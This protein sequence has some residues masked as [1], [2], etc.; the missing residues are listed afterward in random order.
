MDR[1]PRPPESFFD[2]TPPH[3]RAYIDK[4]H[5][6]IDQLHVR[7][8]QSRSSRVVELES[9][10]NKNSQNSSLPPSAAHP[11][12]KPNRKERRS[13]RKRGGQPGHPK[14]E[15]ALIPTDKC[16]DVVPCL[17]TECRKC[18]RELEGVDPDP[19]RH[20]VWELPEIQPI[21]TEYQQHTPGC[22]G[23]DVPPAG[24]CRRGCRPARPGRG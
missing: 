7:I 11:H 23:A 17:P 9:R 2:G 5:G 6:Y 3:V 10:L 1:L 24:R 16:Q 4:L 19:H 18:G 14:A 12:S 20:Q 15:R 13:K 21:V 22:A 8:E